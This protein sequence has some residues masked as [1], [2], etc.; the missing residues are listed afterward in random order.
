MNTDAI[1]TV[2]ES[3]DLLDYILSFLEY[4]DVSGCALV[5]KL[6]HK[7]SSRMYTIK[8]NKIPGSQKIQLRWASIYVTRN[9]NSHMSI[10]QK[11]KKVKKEKR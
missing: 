10:I 6:F 4:Y 5:N 1:T 3:E 9:I 2:M 8:I 11:D 7:I